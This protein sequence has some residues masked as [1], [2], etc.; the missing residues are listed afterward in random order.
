MYI[1]LVLL[2]S[3]VV[4]AG[5]PTQT[6]CY[7]KAMAN[8]IDRSDIGVSLDETDDTVTLTVDG[9]VTLFNGDARLITGAN[10]A[11]EIIT[12]RDSN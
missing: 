11:R 2:A 4:I 6:F 3:I 8:I 10:R 12:E 5:A 7:S 9:E 1:Q